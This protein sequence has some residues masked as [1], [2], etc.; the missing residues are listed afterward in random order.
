M[1]RSR[2]DMGA[3]EIQLEEMKVDEYPLLASSG[4]AVTLAFAPQHFSFSSSSFT[5][6]RKEP[7]VVALALLQH[8]SG[9]VSAF[10]KKVLGLGRWCLGYCPCLERWRY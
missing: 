2:V 4:P 1:R 3:E 7:P 8:C 6:Q 9:E 10:E 5:L